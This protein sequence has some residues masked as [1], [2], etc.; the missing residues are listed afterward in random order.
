MRTYVKISFILLASCALACEFSVDGY[1]KNFFMV[2][3]PAERG[4]T[5][6]GMVGAVNNKLRLKGLYSPVDWLSLHIAYEISPRV[7]DSILFVADEFSTPEIGLKDYRVKD[8]DS[9]LYP[10]KDDAPTSFAIFHNLD[11]LSLTVNLPF[12]DIDIGR[13]PIAW[14]TARVV[15]PTDVI[16]PFSY[17]DLDKEERYGIDAVRIRIPLGMMSELD[18]GYL[19]GIDFDI[20]KNPALYIRSKIYVLGTDISATFIGI[21][22]YSLAGLDFARS[23]GGAGTWLEIAYYDLLDLIADIE[24][25]PLLEGEDYTIIEGYLRVSLGA[26]YSFSEKTYGFIEYHYNGAGEYKPSSYY[27]NYHKVAYKKA[28]VYLMSQNYIAPGA[29]YMFTPLLTGG[30]SG[31][32]NLNDNSAIITPNFEYNIAQDIYLSAG[33]NI[34]FGKTGFE[35]NDDV[36]GY[37]PT[38][39][40]EFGAY[41]D[42]YFTSFRLYF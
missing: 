16:L 30:L 32:Y 28:G 8:F 14:G 33:A 36:E 12:A 13:Q 10:E 17:D 18:M 4:K 7:Q 37:P 26:D 39:K 15:N 41:P 9:R 29:F 20:D 24:Y 11:R 27:R 22:D 25:D 2:V 5:E 21:H 38:G 40:S 3:D 42:L 23:I 35:L 6:Q 19:P 34:G 1:W 31:L